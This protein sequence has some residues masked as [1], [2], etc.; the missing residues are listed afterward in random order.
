MPAALDLADPDS[1]DFFVSENVRFS[2][3]DLVGHVNNVAHAALV[4][5]I[6]IPYATA[7]VE[8]ADLPFMRLMFV[9]LELDF[10]RDLYYPQTVRMGARIIAV[11]NSSFRIGCGVFDDRGCVS[12][13]E[14]VM[15]WLGEDGRS[16][17]IPAPLRAV[18]NRELPT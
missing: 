1:F 9:R 10:R 14:N 12:T 18:L 2:D 6:R 17:P 3:T 13:A 7:L 16:A 4:E 5:S 8:Q 11:G 15:V